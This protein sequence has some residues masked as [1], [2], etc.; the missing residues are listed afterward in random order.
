MR[1][2]R[3]RQRKDAGWTTSRWFLDALAGCRDAYLKSQNVRWLRNQLESLGES[4]VGMAEKWELV[5]TLRSRECA[6]RLFEQLLGANMAI[7]VWGL[8]F[9]V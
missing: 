4:T 3:R 5:S 2:I 7:I 8:W 6:T 9:R 1:L